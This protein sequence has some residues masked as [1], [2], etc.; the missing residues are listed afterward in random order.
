[1]GRG[2]KDDGGGKEGRGKETWEEVR[3]AAACSEEERG[4]KD[5][6]GGEG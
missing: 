1:M 2:G 3:E 6:R 4:Q 5:G